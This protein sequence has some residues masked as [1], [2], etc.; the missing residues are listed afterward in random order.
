MGQ[1]AAALAHELNQ[2]L[3]ATANYVRAAV[4]LLAGPQPDLARIRQALRLAAAADAAQR[5]DHP[6]P[7]RLRRTRRDGAA[8]GARWAQLIEEASALALVGAKERGVKVSIEPRPGPAGGDRG[9]RADP[10]GAAQ[11]DAQ[12]AGGDGER[13][14]ARTVDA[15]SG[16]DG[17]GAGQ[18][19][20]YRQ[21]RFHRRSRRSL[22]QPFVTTKA[23]AWASACRSAAPSSRRMADGCGWSANP[24]GGSVFHFTVP[25]G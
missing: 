14:V 12:R 2:P 16:V 3:T 9:P 19:R 1:M 4:R 13:E 11:P 20:R 21:R 5:R 7:A 24:G 23:T 17:H 15:A 10:A 8:A 25:I 18:R 22:F 6:P